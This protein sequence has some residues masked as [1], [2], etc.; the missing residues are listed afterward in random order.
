MIKSNYLAFRLASHTNWLFNCLVS[1]A[2]SLAL[3]YECSEL[4]FNFNSCMLTIARSLNNP[5]YDHDLLNHIQHATPR[6][7]SYFWQHQ[8]IMFVPLAHVGLVVASLPCLGCCCCLC[9]VVIF[10]GP[11]SCYAYE[12][13]L[14]SRLY[15]L[16]WKYKYLLFYY[17]FDCCLSH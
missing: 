3:D 6:L 16:I 14:E 2:A 15:A 12:P 4:G 9:K 11:C 8:N 1:N 17:S 7:A 5:S 13:R 10:V